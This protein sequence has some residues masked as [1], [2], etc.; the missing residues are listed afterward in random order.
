MAATV[1]TQPVQLTLSEKTFDPGALLR[2]EESAA[3]PIALHIDTGTESVDL[4][5]APV[6]TTQM[7]IFPQTTSVASPTLADKKDNL[8][9]KKVDF[10]K[11]DMIKTTASPIKLPPPPKTFK[12]DCRPPDKVKTQGG[13]DVRKYPI[14]RRML[15]LKSV[16]YPT[17]TE[18]IMALADKHKTN[19][20]NIKL[21]GIFDPIPVR[22][23]TNL[24]IDIEHGV[25][26]YYIREKPI[27]RTGP[28]VARMVYGRL[29]TTGDIISVAMKVE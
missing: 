19:Y 4:K 20:T 16:P 9:L 27:E 28:S 5:G 21:I 1:R 7:D 6:A 17:L 11:I 13:F 29:R 22:L 3:S 8:L 15:D 14:V 24:T 10:F 18:Y 2:M 26:K 23:A 12:A 25:L